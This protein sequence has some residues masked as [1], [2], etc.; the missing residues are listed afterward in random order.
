MDLVFR[1][2][3][4]SQAIPTGVGPAPTNCS[5][6]LSRAI[7]GLSTES[8][9]RESLRLRIGHWLVQS[10]I[11][12]IGVQLTVCRRDNNADP[13]RIV[14]VKVFSALAALNIIPTSE[15][16]ARRSPTSKPPETIIQKH[17]EITLRKDP[18]ESCTK[19]GKISCR[20][21]DASKRL[22]SS[23]HSSRTCSPG[24][25]KALS[26]KESRRRR[27]VTHNYL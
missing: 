11:A 14:E 16:R 24:F 5:L 25:K 1:E 22:D 26:K 21:G 17:L 4:L 27:A 12:A 9:T 3:S 20:R 15:R 18:L 2:L 6:W 13:P 8:A 19:M 10:R 7:C 23:G